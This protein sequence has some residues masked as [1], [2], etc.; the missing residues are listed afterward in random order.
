[1]L[2][3]GPKN[4]TISKK[5]RSSPKFQ[6]FFWPNK[7]ISKKKKK[8]KGL[9]RNF[10]A[11]SGRNQAVRMRLRWAFHFSMSFGWAPSRAHGPLMGPLNSMS[12]GVIFPL[13]PSRRPCLWLPVFGQKF[14]S[15]A[16]T[17]IYSRLRS[18]SSDLGDTARNAIPPA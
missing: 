7:V 3:I 2:L 16:T 12:P 1:M 6:R 18:S 11:L 10:L 4:D 13:P 8:K 5:Q 9:L 15:C 17:K 14:A